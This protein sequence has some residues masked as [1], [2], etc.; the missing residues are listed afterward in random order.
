VTE[1]HSQSEYED[2]VKRREELRYVAGM[3]DGEGSIMLLRQS[4]RYVRPRMTITNLDRH[5]LER[6]RRILR[7]GRIEH[8]HKKKTRVLRLCIERRDVIERV[9]RDLLPFLTL[10][11]PQALLMLRFLRSGQ[12]RRIQAF[13]MAEEMSSL[14]RVDHK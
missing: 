14:N 12:S 6:C 9:V 13:A 1:D 4:L 11:K 7:A 3:L 8:T 2:L 10:K 5:L